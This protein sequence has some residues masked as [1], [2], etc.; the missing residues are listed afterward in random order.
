MLLIKSMDRLALKLI[1][2]HS[3]HHLW[4]R[5]QEERHTTPEDPHVVNVV[6]R[7]KEIGGSDWGELWQ[8]EVQEMTHPGQREPLQELA[9]QSKQSLRAMPQVAYANQLDEVIPQRLCRIKRS[10][11]L[12]MRC[13]QRE[14][15]TVLR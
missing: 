5:K 8:H 10:V 7:R 11:H 3:I 12:Q 6:M 2:I 14:E 15:I 9:E 1:D 4:I 13:A